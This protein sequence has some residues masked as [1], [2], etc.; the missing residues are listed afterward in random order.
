[1]DLEIQIKKLRADKKRAL[2][3]AYQQG[4]RLK[5]YGISRVRVMPTLWLQSARDYQNEIDRLTNQT[6]LL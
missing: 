5:K 3:N 2:K 1:M 4:R 6:T